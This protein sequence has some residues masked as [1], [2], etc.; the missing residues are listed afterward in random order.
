VSQE[1]ERESVRITQTLWARL[2]NHCCNGNATFRS[3]CIV[4]DP[5][6]AVNN[7]NPLSVAMEKQKWA[8][9]VLLPTCK[10]FHTVVKDINFLSSACKLPDGVV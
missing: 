1:Q 7:T 3:L 4:V 5:N 9:F 6:V 8:V 10:I 2:R